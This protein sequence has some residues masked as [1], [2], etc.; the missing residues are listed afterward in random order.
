MGGQKDSGVRGWVGVRGGGTERPKGCGWR[1]VTGK[2]TSQCVR[3]SSVHVSSVQNGVYAVGKALM[4]SAPSLRTFTS[5][6]TLETVA[7]WD[8]MMTDPALSLLLS[9]PLSS[10][11]S[12]A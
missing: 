1:L 8:R 4:R 11:Q 2:P 7:V 9:T 12:K 3:F 6:M 5:A 10:K